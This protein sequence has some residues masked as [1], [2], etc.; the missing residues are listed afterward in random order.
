MRFSDYLATLPDAE[1]S[2]LTNNLT[3]GYGR[4]ALAARLQQQDTPRTGTMLGTLAAAHVSLRA[5]L[6]ALDPGATDGDRPAP[7]TGAADVLPPDWATLVGDGQWEA[8]AGLLAMAAEMTRD[9][10]AA[11]L[12]D[13]DVAV[14]RDLVGDALYLLTTVRDDALGTV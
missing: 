10:V 9:A 14:V 6:T 4:V 8:V 3:L 12:A 1:Q 13:A 11:T 7:Q 5:A 2:V